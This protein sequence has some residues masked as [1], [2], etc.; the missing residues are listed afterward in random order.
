MN[1]MWKDLPG[2]EGLYQVSNL[3]KVK[4]L[5]KYRR[6]GQGMV[7]YKEKIMSPSP[8]KKRLYLNLSLVDS[9]GKKR[10]F[11]VHRLVALT[12]LPQILAKTHVNHKD[13]NRLNNRVDNLEWCTPKENAQHALKMGRYYISRGEENYG[14]K[15]KEEDIKEIR[16]RYRKYDLQNGGK[17]LAKEFGVSN[18]TIHYVVHKLKWSHI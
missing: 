4:S 5:P 17:A 13:C 11:D 9:S 16:S 2:Y 1:E 7:L 6:T 18:V 8:C 3:G 14:A 15:L 10:Q 12:F